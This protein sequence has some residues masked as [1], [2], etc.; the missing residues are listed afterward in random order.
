MVSKNLWIYFAITIPLTAFIISGWLIFYYFFQKPQ[1]MKNVTKIIKDLENQLPPL[2]D[3]IPTV[4][5][6]IKGEKYL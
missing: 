6:P 2:P 3:K 5:G 1:T 4:G